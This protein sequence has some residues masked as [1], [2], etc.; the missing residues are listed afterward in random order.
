RRPAPQTQVRPLD[1][2]AAGARGLP[3]RRRGEGRRRIR[4]QQSLRR[5][6]SE[7]GGSPDRGKPAKAPA[8]YPMSATGTVQSCFS[9]RNKLSMQSKGKKLKQLQNLRTPGYLCGLS[10]PDHRI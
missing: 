5:A 2:A 8:L 9:T 4:A 3:G 10:W 7:Q 1:R 6:L